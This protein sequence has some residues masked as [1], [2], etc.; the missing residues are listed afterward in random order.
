MTWLIV[1]DLDGT[2]LDDHYLN[3]RAA[4]AI[5]TVTEVYDDARIALV[6]S[7]T[8]AEM[9]DLARHCRSDP[10]LI[11]ENGTGMAWREPVLCRRGRSTLAGFEVECFGVPYA[12]VVATLTQ[13]R[14]DHG[15]RFRGFSD[16]TS[17]EVATRTG[18]SQA[19]ADLAQRRVGAEPIVWEGTDDGLVEFDAALSD[20]GLELVLG[21]RF[22][23]VGSHM[24]K[25]RA[26]ARLWRLLRFQFGVRATTLA[27]GDAPND[28]PMMERADHAIVFPSRD[29]AYL[30]PDNPNTL[31]APVA[32]PGAWLDAVQNVL[33]GRTFEESSLRSA[34]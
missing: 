1:T 9:I 27:C 26:L 15:H 5:D 33:G 8:P 20:H 28:V 21:G 6:S 34:S 12:E 17:G 23:H 3:F 30:E 25:G 24:N 14:S 2:L 10:I 32:G 31:R 19:A 16:M 11:F 4:A 22:H 29:G 13:L 18:L 7:K